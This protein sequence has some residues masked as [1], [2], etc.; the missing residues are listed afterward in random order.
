LEAL[1]FYRE[2][3]G[4]P[5]VVVVALFFTTLHQIKELAAAAARDSQEASALMQRF[6]P[7]LL[8]PMFGVRTGFLL[9]A[10]QQRL[11]VERWVVAEARYVTP[12]TVWVRQ[13]ALAASLLNGSTIE[14]N[15]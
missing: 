12:Q 6:T 3:G 11:L 9:L 8:G 13:A 14:R 15:T 7:A 4:A 1:A 2:L 5:V 10:Q